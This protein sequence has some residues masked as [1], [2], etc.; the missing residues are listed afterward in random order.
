MSAGPGV[1]Y[2]EGKDY[3]DK[4]PSYLEKVRGSNAS[5]IL[6]SKVSKYQYTKDEY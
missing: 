3:L 4:G 6:S 5:D 1:T 2:Q